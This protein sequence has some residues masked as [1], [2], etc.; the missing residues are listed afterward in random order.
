MDDIITKP[1]KKIKL[2]KI[3]EEYYYP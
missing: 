3:L 2:Q 1:I